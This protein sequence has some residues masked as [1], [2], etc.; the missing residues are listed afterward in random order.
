[1]QSEN[2]AEYDEV[3][4][5][6]QVNHQ[7]SIV[8]EKLDQRIRPYFLITGFLFAFLL[9]ETYRWYMGVPPM[10]IVVLGLFIASVVFVAYQLADYKDHFRFLRLGKQGEPQLQDAIKLHSDQT[11]STVY[12]EV[13]MGK[14]KIDYVIANQSGVVLINVCDWRTP[15]NDEAIINYGD[16][17]ILLNGYRPDANPIEPLKNVKQWIENKLYA[18]LGKPIDVECLVVFPEW[19]VRSAREHVVVRVINPRELGKVLEERTNVL[20][21]NDKTLLNYNIS[22]LINKKIS[23]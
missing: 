9:L 11:G 4:D 7:D 14:Q 16:E 1:M 19:F 17:Q 21:D 13:V 23:S 3:L 22:K 6:D 18:S 2:V 12:K 10:P 5:E 15:S 8:R 20:S